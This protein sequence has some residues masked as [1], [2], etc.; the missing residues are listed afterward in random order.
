MTEAQNF[1]SELVDANINRATEG[2]RVVEEY[3]RFILIHKDLSAK[4]A[5]IRHKISHSIESQEKLLNSRDIS[6]DARAKSPPSTRKELIDILTANFKRSTEALRVLEEYI[7]DS[8]YSNWRYDVYE[9]EKAI[10]LIASKKF[11][12]L[13]NV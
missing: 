8:Q 1:D 11:L 7:G 2:L 10:I 9:L 12:F 13:K 6:K 3:C 5:H 4:V